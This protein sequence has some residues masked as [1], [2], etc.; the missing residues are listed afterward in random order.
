MV[1]ASVSRIEDLASCGVLL[2][3]AFLLS[4]LGIIFLTVLWS[5]FFVSVLGCCDLYLILVIYT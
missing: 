5:T 2:S 4:I 3:R 1:F